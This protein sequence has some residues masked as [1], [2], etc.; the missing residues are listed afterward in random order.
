MIWE[1]CHPYE[2]PEDYEPPRYYNEGIMEDIH[3]N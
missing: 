1:M 3:K 2:V